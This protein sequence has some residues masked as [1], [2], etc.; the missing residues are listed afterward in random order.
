MLLWSLPEY[1]L[2][3][4]D[5]VPVYFRSNIGKVYAIGI[6]GSDEIIEIPLW[7]ITEPQSKRNA[8]EAAEE[9]ADYKHIYATVN[10]D[11]L[12]MRQSPVNT[13]SQIYRFQEN[14]LIKVL[15]RTEGQPVMRGSTAL[16]GDW[17]WVLANGGTMGWCFSYNLTVFDEREDTQTQSAS[18]ESETVLPAS[19]SEKRWY[20]EYYQRLIAQNTINLLRIRSSYGFNPGVQTGTVTVANESIQLSY[21]YE[22]VTKVNDTTYSFNDTPLTLTIRGENLITIGYTDRIGRILSYNFITFPESQTT[23]GTT[24][25]SDNYIDRIIANERTRRT[26]QYLQI[27]SASPNFFS[28]NYGTVSFGTDGKFAWRDFQRLVD[29][30]IIA[31]VSGRTFAQ[32]SASV[33]YFM[34]SS[35]QAEFDGILTLKFDGASNETNFLYK[36]EADGLRFEAV[37]NYSIQNG[38]LTQRSNNPLIMFFSK[39]S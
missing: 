31:P 21:S 39:Q 4:T 22:G 17:L 35:I 6:P 16:E 13:S 3:D 10:V 11:G 14:E 8:T 38:T 12:V 5:I 33:E 25:N 1:N 30:N 28:A 19:V 15:Y 23:D 29:A 27:V 24:G 34:S 26:E 7:Q 32:G 9:Y 2:S 20:P 36:I 37:D 18:D